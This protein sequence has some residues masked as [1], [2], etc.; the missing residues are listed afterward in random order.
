MK[1]YG[2]GD[3]NSC[4]LKIFGRTEQ[5]EISNLSTLAIY[6]DN[7][8]KTIGCIQVIIKS[9]LDKHKQ[10]KDTFTVKHNQQGDCISSDPEVNT[11]T[12]PE[13]TK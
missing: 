8:S 3:K 5:R 11:I 9:V 2:I 1:A 7:C 4:S 12:F 6:A 10:S 13:K